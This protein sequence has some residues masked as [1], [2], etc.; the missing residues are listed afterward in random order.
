MHARNS[1]VLQVMVNGL[2]ITSLKISRV[3]ST[4]KGYLGIAECIIYLKGHL[5]CL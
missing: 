3:Q 1:W 4:F 2:I 5:M